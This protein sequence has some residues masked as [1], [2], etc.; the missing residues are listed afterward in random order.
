MRQH[1]RIVLVLVGVV[2]AAAVTAGAPSRDLPVVSTLVGAGPLDLV[3]TVQGDGM[4]SYL[5]NVK[6]TSGVESHIQEAGAYELDVYYFTSNRRLYFDLRNV[7][8]GSDTVTAPRGTM[9]VPGRLI[10]KCTA[11]LNLLT[12]EPTI[13]LVNCALHGRFD[14]NGRVMLI[15]M[16]EAAFAGTKNP[17]IT[18]TG[19]N[20]ANSAQCQN[21]KIETC[22]GVDASGACTQWG[23]GHDTIDIRA[24]VMSILEEKTSKGKVT[25]QK[26]ADY[27]MQFEIYAS[28]Q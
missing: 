9:V 14:Y 1:A 17:R 24:N 25:E 23:F 26:V 10:T 20:P 6:G 19:T 22:T 18:C 3:H 2:L 8:P 15:R 12:M 4:G 21:W 13:P 5:H 7:V 11:T 16:D 27:Y 28:K